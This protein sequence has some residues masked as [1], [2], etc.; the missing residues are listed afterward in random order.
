M[1]TTSA[2]RL[3]DEQRHPHLDL[4][5]PAATGRLTLMKTIQ[6]RCLLT[7]TILGLLATAGA[8]HAELVH[9]WTFDDGTAN[10]S[11]GTAHGT[12]Y[13]GATISGGQLRLDGVNDYFRTGPIAETL[14]ARTLMVWVTL[15]NLTQQA[16]SA[17]TLENPT[18]NDTF[19]GII[20]GEQVTNRWING[21]DF[22]LRWNSEIATTASPAETSL[23][24]VWIAIVYG[25]PNS[26]PDNIKIYRNGVLYTDYTPANPRIT[27][28]AGVADVLIGVRHSD[29]VGGTGTAEGFDEFLA[30]A[31]DEARIYNTALTA[32]QITDVLSVVVTNNA[33]SCSG[34][35][36]RIVLFSENFDGIPLG[37]NFDETPIAAN[38][39]ARLPPSGWT[40]DRSGV[41]GDG[42]TE[43][44]GWAFAKSSW[45]NQLAPPDL[46][47]QFTNGTNTILVADGQR[48][49]GLGHNPAGLMTTLISTPPISL[50]GMSP[51]SLSLCFDS[52][53]RPG[54]QQ[55]ALILAS[56]NGDTAVEVMRCESGL[57]SPYSKLSAPNEHVHVPVN[58]PPGSSNVVFTFKYADAGNDHWWAI[59][60]LEVGADPKSVIITGLR[61]LVGPPAQ[62]ELAFQ[63]TVPPKLQNGSPGGLYYVQSSTS[64]MAGVWQTMGGVTFTPTPPNAGGVYLARLARP[65]VNSFYRILAYPGTPTDLDADGLNNLIETNGWNVTI[66]MVGGGTSSRTV[67]SNPLL[68]DTDGDG[69]SDWEENLRA[70]DPANADTDGDGLGDHEEVYVYF[71]NPRHQD[72]DGDGLTD[73]AEVEFY[74]TS[75]VLADTDGDGLTDYSEATDTPSNP[76]LTRPLISDLPS[77]LITLVPEQTTIELDI[78]YADSAGQETSYSATIGKSQS[79][80]LGR[81]DSRTTET[82]VETSASITAGVEAGFPGGATASVSAT[83]GVAATQTEGRTTTVD[84]T[85]TMEVNNQYSRYRADSSSRTVSTGRG[86]ISVIFQVKNNG[87]RAFTI[88]NIQILARLRD[89][90]RTVVGTLQPVGTGISLAPG[91]V[92]G[93]LQAEK[94][95]LLY[96]PMEKVFANP[97]LLT[98]AVASFDVTDAQGVNNVFLQEVNLTRTAGL[99]IDY[100]NGTNSFGTN[101][102]PERYRVATETEQGQGGVT[103]AS[104]FQ[105]SFPTAIPYKVATQSGTGHRVLTEV[106]GIAFHTSK[107]AIWAVATSGVSGSTEDFDNIG[108]KAGDEVQ[109]FYVQDQDGDG[110]NDRE[111]FILGSSDTNPD[112]DGDGITDYDE[113]KTGWMVQVTLTNNVTRNYQVF[114]DPRFAD[115]DGDGLN[116]ASERAAGTDPRLRDTDG[117]GLND[118]VDLQPLTFNAPPANTLNT[119]SANQA[120]VS[121]SGTATGTVALTSVTINWGDG[122]GNTVLTPPAN[123]LNYPYSANHTYASSGSKTITSTARDANNFTSV[124]TRQVIVTIGAPRNGLIGEYLFS[125][126]SWND[127]SGANRHLLAP[128]GSTEFASAADRNGQ[129]N[130]AVFFLNQN[131]GAG[132]SFNYL[133]TPVNNRWAYGT[134]YTLSARIQVG[135]GFGVI[136]GQEASP[137]LSIREGKVRFGHPTSNPTEPDVFVVDPANLPNGTWVHFAVTASGSA[138][139]RTFRLYR[140]GVQVSSATKAD[141]FAYP[142][143]A[144]G[145]VGG[146][147]SSQGNPDGDYALGGT[148]VDTVRIYNRALSAAEIGFLANDAQ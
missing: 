19:D 115:L 59:D 39:W 1:K 87:P 123:T 94:T 143:N 55:K 49:S 107:H 74:R 27:Y 51:G 71:S 82:A 97:T 10:D 20:Y 80:A 136:V 69:L 12:L 128:Q 42:V 105:Q 132:G 95:D 141:P 116:D 35:L 18:G 103:L 11:T 13:N 134:A 140:N 90:S 81:S 96:P 118:N 45:W 112:T 98:F 46:R 32:S 4:H 113:V 8:A 22:A 99:T 66:T 63:E 62:V 124:A 24:Q 145:L 142:A 104:V 64:A 108:L 5:G 121:I 129:A 117:D 58:N 33:D 84:M 86:R 76:N 102:P 79:T 36:R 139:S 70:T 106:R 93:Q 34:S 50:K 138:G 44:A 111:E 48:W 89:A 47:G 131:A 100:G 146:W 147:G 127:T 17:L 137:A 43:W 52:S 73:G 92:S 28:P 41:P 135:S 25:D 9:R 38:V 85:Q 75:P 68:D 6:Q 54:G 88:S 21:S 40:H 53:W 2:N 72:T 144:V 120:V 60:N 77:P 16:G 65:S 61:T 78:T 109:L 133:A 56:F 57:L 148:V 122:T 3:C 23:G 83:V 91:A 26:S 31:I 7:F 37:A 29:L 30:G 126:F 125:N 14:S 110:L 130:Q 15:S 119:P 67:T 101:L 114:S